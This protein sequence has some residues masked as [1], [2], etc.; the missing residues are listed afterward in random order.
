MKVDISYLKKQGV[1]S[2]AY[3]QLFTLAPAD[4]PKPLQRLYQLITERIRKGREFNFDNWKPYAAIDL[5]YELPFNQTTPTL[6]Q[7]ILSQ[8]LDAEKTLAA[9]KAWGLNEKELFITVRG[10]DNTP[11]KLL[12]PPVFYKV[13]IPL[14]R[15][16]CGIR[17]AKLYND[18]NTYP[19]LPYLPLKRV[20]TDRVACEVLTDLIASVSSQY[21]YSSTLRS[22]IQHMLKY[23]VAMSMPLE[24]WHHE[25][26]MFENVL[27]DT[28]EVTVR[29]GIRYMFPHPTRLFYDLFHPLHTINTDTGVDYVGHWRICRYGD[30]LRDRKYWNRQGVTFGSWY[31]MPTAPTYFQEMYPCQV[32]WPSA[33]YL[34][35]NN[36]EK[37]AATY[38]YNMDYDCGVMVTHLFMKIVPA[39]YGLAN[40]RFPVWHRFDVANDDTVLWAAP[41][42]YT[43][44]WMFGYDL[45][46]QS[47]IQSSMALETIPFQDHIGNI[48][49]QMVLTS[50]QNLA[51]LTY[52]DTVMVDADD[53]KKLENLGERVFRSLN[54]VPFD[55]AKAQRLGAGPQQAF[56]SVQFPFRDIQPLVQTLG[57]VL[58]IMERV[59]QM[60]A[61][62]VGA[63]AQHYQSAREI[64]VTANATSNRLSYTGSFVDDGIDAWKRQLYDAVKAYKD[65]KIL[66]EISED[67]ENLDEAVAS[68][69]FAVKQRS[70]GGVQ[71]AGHMRGLT[72]DTFARTQTR[73]DREADAQLAQVIYQMVT[74]VAQN[75]PLFEEVGAENILF[76][77]EEA[78]RL[79]SGENML[80]LPRNLNQMKPGQ[81]QQWVM[82]QLQQ[83]Q[84]QLAES[85]SKNVAEPAAKK[86]AE[87]EKSIAGL[88]DTVKKLGNIFKVAERLAQK[89][90]AER[91]AAMQEM[92]IEQAKFISDEQRKQ[93]AHDADLNRK[94]EEA[95]I[96]KTIAV[97]KAKADISVKRAKAG[98]RP[99]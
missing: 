23:G 74:V 40:Y 93:Q 76:L 63:A 47:A 94:A 65:P 68:L 56:H 87:H 53:I 18:R 89:G 71:I 26:Q 99:R 1:H 88:E 95:A 70:K 61:Q 15:A 21:G 46:E 83:L 7:N 34:S 25:E 8:N 64:S 32:R 9:M 45:D 72:L 78:A 82:Q 39:H 50:K 54:F 85:I 6:V 31:D 24:E 90:E 52:Y 12:N 73:P 84:Q 27:G 30:I 17:A 97:E 20:P 38:N 41:C 49:T 4:R 66:T 22:G 98:A 81:L 60:S 36:R 51:N 10:K 2:G 14:T 57:S 62:E 13:L 16:Y 96:K 5:A 28:E 19:L 67:I 77:V 86:A 44:S 79:A 29:E 42:A 37:A 92:K 80:K 43:P 48:I 55:S 3:K 91:E 35:E 33:S 59:L 11:M 58:N 69:G 75:G